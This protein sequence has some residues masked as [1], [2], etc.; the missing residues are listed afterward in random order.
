MKKVVRILIRCLSSRDACFLTILCHR[1]VRSCRPSN[2]PALCPHP[3]PD[4]SI[5]LPRRRVPAP[6]TYRALLV[7]PCLRGQHRSGRAGPRCGYDT[8]AG[9]L[10]PVHP[11][12]VYGA[13]SAFIGD[14]LT[15]GSEVSAVCSGGVHR[16]PDSQRQVWRDL[17][18]SI[19]PRLR[20]P[21]SLAT[22][23]SSAVLS[24]FADCIAIPRRFSETGV[25]ILIVFARHCTRN[26]AKPNQNG[27]VSCRLASFPSSPFL[28]EPPTPT[29]DPLPQ[30]VVLFCRRRTP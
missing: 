9:G 23:V 29:P 28:F 8:A 7:G 16:T 3:V 5:L 2:S 12:G 18:G 15:R 10:Y 6:S 11:E 22:A 4:C 25:I 27:F 17:R 30:Y 19:F 14:F 26:E 21:C 1:A 24:D 13:V 20:C